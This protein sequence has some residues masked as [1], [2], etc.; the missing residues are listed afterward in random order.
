[1]L[2]IQFHGFASAAQRADAQ[3]AVHAIEEQA[4]GQFGLGSEISSIVLFQNE[5]N[6]I[7]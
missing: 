2:N 7:R 3:L 5:N 6:E 1:V 4:D